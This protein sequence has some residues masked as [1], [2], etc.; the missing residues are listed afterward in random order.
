VLSAT[1]LLDRIKIGNDAGW[2]LTFHEEKEGKV[3]EEPVLPLSR[4]DYY[5]EISAELPE[6][7]EGGSYTFTV[8]GMTDEHYGKIAQ[9]GD[10]QPTVI[11]LHLFWRDTNSSIGGYVSS[12]AGITDRVGTRFDE[13]SL[14]AE[15]T[16]KKV[17]R[18]KGARHYEAKIEATERVFKKLSARVSTPVKGETPLETAKKL[19]KSFKLDVEKSEFTPRKTGSKPNPYEGSKK[20]EEGDRAKAVDIMKALGKSMEQSSGKFGR[21]MLLIR[22]GKLI[23]GEREFVE[24]NVKPLT[25]TSG[26]IAVKADGVLDVEVAEDPK[27]PGAQAKPE[28]KPP[29][30]KKYKLTLKGR[31]D[32]FPGDLVQF[33][34]PVEEVATTLG[35]WAGIVGDLVKGPLLPTDE[36]KNPTYLYISGVSHKLG[37]KSGFQTVVSG[38]EIKSLDD[39]WDKGPPS[40]KVSSA[41]PEGRAVNALQKQMKGLVEAQRLDEVAEVRSMTVSGTEEPPSQTLLLWRGIAQ[42]DGNPNAGRRLPITRPSPAPAEGSAYLTPYAWGKTGLVLPRYPGTR[43]LVSHRGGEREDAIDV[44]ALWES[45]HGP[46]SEPGDWWLILPI[47]VPKHR[48]QTLPEGAVPEEHIGKVSQDLIDAEGNRIIEVGELTVRVGLNKMK[49]AGERPEHPQVRKAVTIEHAVG[50]AS[51][52][53]DEDGTITI[54]GKRIDIKSDGD[55]NLEATTVNVR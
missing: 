44:G 7:L 9:K 16:I 31:P 40:Q 15:L 19:A 26:L 4:D 27:K 42:P 53:I 43:V 8:E 39:P 1:E 10:D 11:R 37:R 30:R 29:K 24:K 45:G 2:G 54:H 55:L 36:M 12:L 51:I 32:L 5:A 17:S 3:V 49:N 52:V 46:E 47:D 20:R 13:E 33:D 23:I 48:R 34:P 50:G 14:V 22:K 6:G 21:G 28:K 41:T 35:S 25:W 38:V 18:Q